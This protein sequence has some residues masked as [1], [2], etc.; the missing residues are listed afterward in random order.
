MLICIPRINFII[1]FFL[2]ILH[3]KECCKLVGQ[4][5]FGPQFTNQ[6]FVRQEIGGEMT[7][8]ISVFI[9]DYFLEN[10]MTKLF[11]KNPKN[12]NLELFWALFAQI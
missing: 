1:H 5:D 12:S 11:K 10:L 8:T 9:L 7:I 4:Q 2:E 3:F 6:N